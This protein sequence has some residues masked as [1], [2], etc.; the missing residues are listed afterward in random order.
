MIC[1]N[2][3]Q[4]KVSVERVN[5]TLQDRLVKEIHL[6]HIDRMCGS[7]TLSLISTNVLLSC[8]IDM[9]RPLRES[10]NELHDIFAWQ[11]Q[12]NMIIEN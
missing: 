2:S 7:P 4:A 6:Q 9:H 8:S 10:E 5:K 3:P 12:K 11:E 1:T